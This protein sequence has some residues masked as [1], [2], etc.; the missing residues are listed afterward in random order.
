MK[1]TG[2]R[3]AGPVPP[4]GTFDVMCAARPG[5]PSGSPIL[6][7]L[8]ERAL[9]VQPVRR[10]LHGEAP[11]V[12]LTFDDGPDPVYTPQV[13]DVLAGHGVVATFFL[14]GSR[15]RRHQGLVQRILSS[16]HRV[17]S[18]SWSHPVPRDTSWPSLAVDYK[19]GQRAVGA[20]SGEATSLFRPPRGQ[21]GAKGALTMRA[22]RL[23]P[24]L[25]TVDPEDWRPGIRPEEILRAAGDLARGDVVLLHDGLARPMS[26]EASDRSSTVRALPQ[27]IDAAQR[28][29][30]ELV[31]LPADSNGR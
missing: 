3:S 30:L 22:L 20:T 6:R 2:W 7:R 29:G 12:A 16:G 27:I 13:L 10:R 15:A 1:P 11:A 28:R 23:E 26:P 8:R 9:G 19:R 4:A 24:W 5:P 14:V 17:G 21:V 31:T 18:H 25:W